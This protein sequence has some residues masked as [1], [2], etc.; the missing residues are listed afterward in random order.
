[1]YRMDGRYGRERELLG[2]A[3]PLRAD[4]CIRSPLVLMPLNGRIS[5]MPSPN[6]LIARA[7]VVDSR[8]LRNV[9]GPHI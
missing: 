2:T 4:L 7:R 8:K 6:H 5:P 1:M 9:N 3:G